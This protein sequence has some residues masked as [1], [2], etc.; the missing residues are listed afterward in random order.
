MLSQHVSDFVHVTDCA[1]CLHPHV[2]LQTRHGYGWWSVIKVGFLKF[3]KLVYT[4]SMWHWPR[5]F[6]KFEIT[7]RQIAFEELRAAFREQMK[8]SGQT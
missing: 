5:Y 8:N 1:D 7:Q 2:I 4:L 3:Q 6:E